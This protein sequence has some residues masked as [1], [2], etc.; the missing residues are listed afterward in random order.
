M[1]EYNNKATKLGLQD[2]AFSKK[3]IRQNRILFLLLKHKSMSNKELCEKLGCSEATVRNDLREL[4]Q[5]KLIKRVFGGATTLDDTYGCIPMSEHLEYA[6]EEKEAIADYVAENILKPNQ[7]VVLDMGSTCL[8]LAKRIATLSFDINIVTNSLLNAEAISKNP[9]IYLSMPGGTYNITSDTFDSARTLEYYDSIRPDCYLMSANGLTSG[10]VTITMTSDTSRAMVKQKIIQSANKV[11][12]LCDHNK[13][14]KNCF[15]KVCE[16]SNIDLIVT[17]DKCSP[18]DRNILS[19][20]GAKVVFAP[21]MAIV[22][23]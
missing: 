16:I 10:G 2:Y 17:D 20:L 8:A 15:Y 11:I 9:H 12:L 14:N 18:E 19:D 4:S 13:L 3:G 22:P 6:Y 5:L 23:E 7:S 1:D 21:T